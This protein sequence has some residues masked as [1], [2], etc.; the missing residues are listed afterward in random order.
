MWMETGERKEGQLMREGRDV[1]QKGEE[2]VKLSSKKP[3]GLA[4]AG[5]AAAVEE[6]VLADFRVGSVASLTA[7]GMLGGRE[8]GRGWELRAIRSPLDSTRGGVLKPEGELVSADLPKSSW[9][10]FPSS[11]RNQF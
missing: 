9:K 7:L 4:T 5:G 6:E 8:E 11:K 10:I 3:T 2:E 1:D